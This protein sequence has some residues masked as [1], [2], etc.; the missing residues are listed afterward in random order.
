[1]VA[2][3]GK[4]TVAGVSPVAKILFPLSELLP[5]QPA[6]VDGCKIAWRHGVVLLG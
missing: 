6:Q 5:L 3:D 2:S 4:P 1:M